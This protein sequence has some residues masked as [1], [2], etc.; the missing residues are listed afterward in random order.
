MPRKPAQPPS[1]DRSSCDGSVDDLIRGPQYAL[2]QAEKDAQLLSILR[3]LCRQV[4]GQ[5]EPYARFLQ[6]FGGDVDAWRTVADIPP[7]PVSMM[8][9]TMLAIATPPGTL[10]LNTVWASCPGRSGAAYAMDATRNAPNVSATAL[11]SLCVRM[12]DSP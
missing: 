1:D 6:R 8:G 11:P 5:C 12:V 4:A 10:L 3:P 7:L 9:V 2:P